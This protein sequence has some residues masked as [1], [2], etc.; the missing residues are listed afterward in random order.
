MLEMVA[1]KA[2]LEVHN[3][4]IYF[5]HFALRREDKNMVFNGG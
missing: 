3:V 1:T 5:Q 2:L 4:S